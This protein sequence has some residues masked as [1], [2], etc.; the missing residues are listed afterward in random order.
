MR[1]IV[2][3]A[4]GD[5]SWRI[6]LSHI[7]IYNPAGWNSEPARVF[8]EPMLKKAGIDPRFASGAPLFTIAFL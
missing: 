8:W 7:P 4:A 2:L 5:A 6:F 1:M 3:N